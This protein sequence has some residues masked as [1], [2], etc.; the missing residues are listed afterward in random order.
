MKHARSMGL[1]PLMNANRHLKSIVRS[2]CAL[3][4]LPA[5]AIRRGFVTLMTEAA[6]RNVLQQLTPFF[7]YMIETWLTQRMI[8]KLSVFRLRHRTNN[9]AE[10]VNK[11]L[12]RRTGAHRP[13]L[14]HFL[15]KFN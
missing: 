10:A 6:R 12:R 8:P 1:V 11:V 2:C 14:W 13:G 4:L 7:D 3:A 15:S 5:R 9:V